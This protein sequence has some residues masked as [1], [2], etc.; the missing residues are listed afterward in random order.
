MC[1]PLRFQLGVEYSRKGTPTIEG[2][3][4]N[5]LGIWPELSFLSGLLKAGLLDRVVRMSGISELIDSI[6][7][8]DAP[9]TSQPPSL[10]G[11]EGLLSCQKQIPPSPP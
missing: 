8:V 2:D 7:T 9:Q 11:G 6:S 3:V 5:Q 10:R 1:F 4:N